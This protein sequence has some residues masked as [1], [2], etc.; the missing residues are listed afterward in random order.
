[1]A[2]VR[3]RCYVHSSVPPFQRIAGPI[4]VS[5]PDR[6]WGLSEPSQARITVAGADI[7]EEWIRPGMCWVVDDSSLGEPIWAGFVSS[8]VIP[9]TADN[10]DI[11]LIGPKK[12]M[13]EIEFAVRLPINATRAY[14]IRQAI[15]AAQVRH[16]GILPGNIDATEGAAVPMDVR[17]E[18]I[19]DFID[20]L[21]DET[22]LAEWRERV[23]PLYGGDELVFYLD[24][25]KLQRKT[26]IVLGRRDLVDGLFVRERVPASLTLMG[27]NVGFEQRESATVALESGTSAGEPTAGTLSILDASSRDKITE[28]NIGPASA[29]HVT[30]ISERIGQ[31]ITSG[32]AGRGAVDL[33]ELARQKHVDELRRMDEVLLTVDMTR[34]STQRVRLGDVI[35]LDVP[36]WGSPIT[37]PLYLNLHVI[38]T[39]INSDSGERRLECRLI[40]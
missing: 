3:T 14:V 30:V 23:E 22:G 6:T 18:T 16:G 40:D 19:S 1:M 35:R 15:E 28:R 5:S 31:L 29:R 9:L 34:T 13:L 24:F 8:Q 27:S 11:E 4:F 17:G 38:K 32:E 37:T 10:L 2:R 12:A 33:S 26:D 20:T 21:H 7:N 39:E 25:G 36:D